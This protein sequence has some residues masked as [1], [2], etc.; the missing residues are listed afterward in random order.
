MS[1]TWIYQYPCCFSTDLIF[2]LVYASVPV[3]NVYSSSLSPSSQIYSQH[4]NEQDFYYESIQIKLKKSG[5]YSFLSYSNID[6]YGAI[7]RKTFNPL[8]P[9]ENLFQMEDDTSSNLQFRL[10]IFL[11]DD[12]TYV[13][14]MATYQ[15]EDA[16]AFWI[17]ALGDNNVILERFSE[18]ICIYTFMLC[19]E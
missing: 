15:S 14:V 2:P 1:K 9:L 7:Y 16:N 8:N 12:V 13:L 17:V 18:Y 10:D 5:Y 11:S 19:Y 6:A 3:Q 4:C